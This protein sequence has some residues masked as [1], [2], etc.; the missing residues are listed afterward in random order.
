MAE[1]PVFLPV[2]R[3]RELVREFYCSLTWNPGFAPTQKKKNVVA[4]HEAAARQGYVTW[5]GQDVGIGDGSRKSGLVEARCLTI[6][7]CKRL[8]RSTA[9]TL[10]LNCPQPRMRYLMFCTKS[11]ARLATAVG[12][13]SSLIPQKTPTMKASIG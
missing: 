13:V 11:L 5:T 8:D 7:H 6:D 3:S 1:R 2:E 4:L 12:S 9:S 10:N